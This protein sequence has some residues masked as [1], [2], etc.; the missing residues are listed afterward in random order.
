M[1]TLISNGVLFISA[2][3]VV[4]VLVLL[5]ARV[6]SR[7]R[8]QLIGSEDPVIPLNLAS[9]NDAVI[10]ANVGGQ[11]TFA[12]DICRDWFGTE[13]SEPDLW[14]LAQRVHPAD[15]F[16]EL[17]ATEGQA[18]FTVGERSIEATS[19]RVT[20]GD[21][22]QFIVVL[23]EEE[24]LPVLDRDDRGSGRALA[25]LA[26]ITRQINATLDLDEVMSN[27]LDGTSRLLPFD[28]AQITL[29][30]QEKDRLR[31][32]ARSGPERYVNSRRDEDQVIRLDEGFTGWIARRRQP[33]LVEDLMNF[34]GVERTQHPLHPDYH[35]F[36]GVPL[37]VRNR[38]IGTL[39]LMAYEPGRYD[40]EDLSLAGL[41]ADQAAIAIENARQYQT[42]AVRVTEL[43]GLQKIAEAIGDLRDPRQLYA[44]LGQ[45]IAE[46]MSVEVAGV[47]LYDR[48]TE[49]L[50][51]QRPVHGMMD[52]FATRY[53]LNLAR[54]SATRTLWED[55]DF[56]FTNDVLNDH[57]VEESGLGELA[58]LTG[59]RSIAMAAMVVGDER[60]G[61]LQ[62]SNKHDGVP[63]NME[64]IRLLRTY[65]NQAAIIVESA[66]LYSEEQSRVA[67]L[68]GLQQIAQTMSSFTNPE[69]LFGQLT[70]RI[71]ELMSVETCGVLL[72]DADEEQLVARKPLYGIS[73]Q[74]AEQFTFSVARRGLA[75]E[76]WRDYELFESNHVFTDN[77]IDELGIRNIARTAGLQTLLLAPL[78][79][80]G[81]RFGMLAVA[82]KVDGSDFDEDDK[83]VVAI[84]ASQAAALIDNARLYQDTDATLR[85][86]AAELRSVSRISR[87]LNATIALEPILEVIAVEAQRAEG[88]SYCSVVMFDF[89]E[90]GTGI[91]PSMRFGTPV[92]EEAVILE[93]AAARSGETLIIEDFERVPHYPSPIPG[94]RC[95]LIAP[96][97]FEGR[98]VGVISLYG[99]R[100]GALGQSAAE[101]VQALCSQATIAVT[102]ATRH[103]EQVERSEII[104]RRA[105]QLTQIF[106]LGRAFRSDQS[107][108]D[109][110]A[111]VARAVR[112]SAGFDTV[113]ITVLGEK[114]QNLHPVASVGLDERTLQKLREVPPPWDI[115]GAFLDEKY[116][117]SFSF[118]V[119][120]EHSEKLVGALELPL[121]HTGK[122]S[123]GTWQAGDV[124]LIPLRS[125]SDELMGLMAIDR[126]RSGLLPTRDTIELLEIFGNQASVVIEN[127]R[128]YRSVEERAQELSRSLTSLEKSYQEL[129]NL[130]Q[131]MIRKDIELSQA[132]ELLNL[133]AQR[134]LALHRIMESVDTTRE[135]EAVLQQIA[136]SVVN[137]MDIDKCIVAVARP[138]NGRATRPVVVAAEGS[139]PPGVPFDQLINGEDAISRANSSRE[140]LLY[141]LDGKESHATARLAKAIGA[142]TLASIPMNLGRGEHGVLLLGSSEPGA[143]FD[144]D[145]RD[146]FTLLAS[147]IGVE[148]EN[149]RLYGAVQSEASTAA[150][151]RDRLQQLHVITT[152]L[153]QA[154]QPRDRLSVIAR[155]IRSVGWN[156]V[157][158]TLLDEQ[159]NIT[160]MAYAG[161]SADEAR[162]LREQLLPPEVWRTR[163]EDQE[164]NTLRIGTSYFLPGDHAWVRR[165]LQKTG[166]NGTPHDPTRWHPDD[167]LYLPLFAGTS[168]VG[169]IKLGDPQN[170]LRPT[171]ES[172]RPLELFAQQAASALENARLYQE[173]LELQSFNEAVLQSIQ[174]G[175]VVTDAKGTIESLNS[176]IRDVYGWDEKLV[177]QH[178]FDARPDLEALGLA[179]DLEQVIQS[180]QHVERTNIQYPIA[181]EL[182]TINIYVYP[183]LDEARNVSGSVLLLEDITQR[184]RLEADIARRAQQLA[185]LTEASR[186]ITATLKLDVVMRSALDNARNV[187]AHDRAALWL[188]NRAN[189]SLRLAS[190]R[191]YPEAAKLV[192]KTLKFEENPLFAQ[193]TG[194]RNPHFLAKAEGN[195]TLPAADGQAHSWLGT[196]MLSGGEII[197]V[198]VLERTG[199][200]PFA[201]ADTQIA[202]A[203][204]NQVAVAL[205]NA[206]LFEEAADRATALASRTRRL[207][208]LNRISAT[209]GQ[210][211]D[212]SSIL[213]TVV[214]ELALALDADHGGIYIFEREAEQA[215]MTGMYP[216]TPDGSVPERII[217]LENNPAVERL[218][219]EKAPIPIEDVT[220]DPLMEAMRATFEADG[221]QSSMLI[222]LVVGNLV[223][224][225]LTIDFCDGKHSFESEQ[226]ELVQTITNQAAVS[227]QNARLFQET[228]ARQRD[229]SLL[230]EAGQI[231]S[232]SLDLETVV[233]S[234]SRYM[235]GAVEAA[236]CMISLWDKSQDT[237]FALVR[238][239]RD[240]E[241]SLDASLNRYKLADYPALDGAIKQRGPVTFDVVSS[242]LSDNE[243]TWWTD[244]SI[245]HVLVIPLIA[246]D[247]PIGLVELWETSPERRFSQ[248]QM[249][250]AA[251]LSNTISTAM[252]NAR[253][254]D[255]TQ[256]RLA[257]LGRINQISRA[258]TQTISAEDLYQILHEQISD[259]LAARS[260]TIA[261]FDARSRMLRFPL[262]VRANRR[263]HIESTPLAEDL[264]SYMVQ[265]PEPMI[266]GRGISKRFKEL[267]IKH[268]EP[269]LRSLLAVPLRSGEAVLGVLTVEDHEE[270]NTFQEADLRVLGPIAAQVAVS[271][272]NTRLYSEL[273][274]RLSETTTLQEVSRVVNS[275][276][277]LN[278]I[279]ERVVRELA[280]A[281]KYPLIGLYT[282]EDSTLVLKASHG[283]DVEAAQAVSRTPATQG[284]MGRA[285]RSGAPQFVDD[286][287]I[288]K[289]YRAVHDWVRCEVAVPIISDEKV[290]G[291]LDIQAGADRM[292]KANDLQLL[293]TFGDQVATAM[294]NARLYAQ[295]VDLSAELERRVEERTR[296]LK[297]E[298]DRI[299]TLYRIA[300]ELTAS[301]DLDRVLNR[302]LEL[303]GEAVGAEHGSLYLVDPQSDKLIHRAVMRGSE[304]LPP[305]GRQ[306]P[307]SRHEGMAGWVMDNR[308]S[309]VVDD[310]QEDPRWSNVPGTEHNRALLGAPL[311]ANYEVLGCIFFTS[312]HD[313]AFSQEHV[314]LVEA[315]AQQVAN[316]INNAELYRM[317][318]DQA[319]RLGVML[320]SQQT[321]AAKSQAILESVADGVMVSDQAGEIILFNAAAERV[322]ELRRDEVLGRPTA[323]LAGLYGPYADRWAPTLYEWGRQPG[324]YTGEF[325]SEQIH[326]ADKVV[327][328][329]VSPV[330][331]GD[332]YL[333]LVYVF[334]DITREVMSDRI[335]TQFVANVSHELRTPMTVIKGYAD[336]LLMGR[337]GEV[338]PDQRDYLE[339]IKR[340]ADRLS[341]LVND[342]LDISRIEQGSVE[343]DLTD[344]S[345]A[346]VINDVI[347]ATRVRC[348]NEGRDIQFVTEMPE[349]LPPVQADSDRLIQIVNNLIS[350]AYQYTP[351]GGHVAVRA[352]VDGAGIQF[353]VEDTGIGIPAADQERVFDR[354]FRGEDPLVM[355]SA[356]TGLGLSIVQHLVEMHQGRVWFES[357]EGSGTTFS[358]WLPLVQES[359]VE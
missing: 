298:R 276:L 329:H 315:A 57:I 154:Q 77:R 130:S 155:G 74:A 160:E 75:R 71:A 291:V 199:E 175:I 113:L 311:V 156:R 303:V 337:A 296:Q 41:I 272:E 237:L 63:F 205:E 215:T 225:M 16:L 284:I 1:D 157:V 143:S 210:S 326:I 158:A 72:Y 135:P 66:R 200:T 166:G 304:I 89:D 23:R 56:W 257:E 46:L 297:E 328:V 138:V 142:Q 147:Q 312:D 53:E 108:E 107:V 148:F 268:G 18:T 144:D 256:K 318:R 88:A 162:T 233:S 145:E 105:E 259:V 319:E 173:T 300:V 352:I 117:L 112:E 358:V 281:F 255:E 342:L 26:E 174:Q 68:E 330:I 212:Q 116:R 356:G 149:A 351:D 15:A 76:V 240:G 37:M 234:A 357:Q 181:D 309:I 242:T 254:H 203:Y 333:G 253:L 248:R 302:A 115:V 307:L 347:G 124:I 170:G 25:L 172:L 235:L 179:R 220:S 126:P 251:S 346:A 345:L 207:A 133:R 269:S 283:Y 293:I 336:L 184:A 7:R 129:D 202:A 20:V 191:G 87:E 313:G 48:E 164:F 243:R 12:N 193:V 159:M 264:Y 221:I 332:E 263:I 43:T 169:L 295:M 239:T 180:G 244:Q 139:V 31:P 204:A 275:A 80:A 81:R 223:T 236:G 120:H 278:E 9:I 137:E 36:V 325:L 47:L 106:E 109:N 335:K 195:T 310:V 241:Q 6:A 222:P 282:Y 353:D 54:G 86:R 286:V 151:E 211:L 134:L 22:T 322:L 279:F 301:L 354:F 140:P 209:L 194:S 327:S 308:Q 49:R 260:M 150:A 250:L 246:R 99:R 270:E 230:S 65:A 128:L 33:L 287:S 206:R 299:D 64:D 93:T 266:I 359:V 85:K 190:A 123:T 90:Q 196:P 334:R 104:R 343:L 21:T 314:R 83:R 267:G 338:N 183:R 188:A 30:E 32:A 78:S 118:F 280:N 131:E 192:G 178:I 289:D 294:T 305:G 11:I 70:Q 34:S 125:T 35:S 100:P 218:R 176:F 24:P 96:I 92:G 258:L 82:N 216:S 167:S 198:L 273:E 339:R 103:A 288:D 10:V 219:S 348:M 91:E 238:L 355:K 44:Q 146:L 59:M 136:T 95:A 3:A 229:L 187:L 45:R 153:Q 227:V 2:G 249:R 98:T 111:S 214:D 277:D 306:I 186:D 79:A 94:V 132:N 197:G 177:G 261:L 69:Q 271:I 60:I 292:L 317:I 27:T 285:A 121:H 62:V 232:S 265:N 252:E 152:A 50:V 110:L 13:N 341:L 168:I 39:E 61:V 316:S 141:T 228:V 171:E 161:Y 5:T 320:R 344:V 208:L 51:A 101:F 4:I 165:H 97:F 217:P 122:G 349:D 102:N 324:A 14:A 331:H 38:F 350:N 245:A 28:A 42:Q 29:L 321:E 290:L 201:A 182:R 40:R 8:Q 19:H 119:S 231:A 55:V 224:G 189:N 67:E 73:D 340:H 114:R 262:A 58:E 84:F 226:I 323:D 274:Q 213:Q 185:A 17:F 52:V 163:F 247:E 127:S